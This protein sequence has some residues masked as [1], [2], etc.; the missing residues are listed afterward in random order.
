MQV[1]NIHAAPRKAVIAVLGISDGWF[2]K[3][4]RADVLHPLT[5][6]GTTYDLPE[7]VRAYLRFHQDGQGTDMA[8]EK[9][10]L[11]VA[12]R[13]QIEQR[14]ASEERELVPVQ[15]AQAAFSAVMS[16]LAAQLDGLAGRMAGELAGLDDPAAVR[17]A[18]F[19]ETRRIRHG[20]A[21][22]LENF[23]SD[24]ERRQP[25]EAAAAANG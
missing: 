17:E 18:L 2:H 15:E 23:A 3:L 16:M 8:T 25:A 14:T 10:K 5:D 11:V 12:Q 19:I 20:A 9:L 4:R 6:K 21:Q 24:P 7:C 22:Q 1:D 13:K